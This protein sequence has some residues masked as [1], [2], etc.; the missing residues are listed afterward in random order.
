MTKV[1]A[2]WFAVTF[3]FLSPALAAEKTRQPDLAQ[4]AESDAAKQW[5]ELQAQEQWVARLQKQIAGETKQLSE[6]RA[7][8]AADFK[9]DPKKL[10]NGDYTYD[11]KTDQF[12][13]KKG[14]IARSGEAATKQSSA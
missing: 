4:A 7:K 14:V 9:L 6:M 5:K 8:L 10:E 2:A 3:L 13:D 1:P 12:I 11:S